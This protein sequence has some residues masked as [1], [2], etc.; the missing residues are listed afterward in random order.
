MVVDPHYSTSH[1]QHTHSTEMTSTSSSY[2]GMSAA[3]VGADLQA[4]KESHFSKSTQ[5]NNYAPK[6]A[7]VKLSIFEHLDPLHSAL[8]LPQTRHR[9]SCYQTASYIPSKSAPRSILWCTPS[10][11]LQSLLPL[12][13]CCR[14]SDRVQHN[15]QRK[16]CKSTCISTLIT[17]FLFRVVMR[18]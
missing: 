14:C 4:G 17:T 2:G 16:E 9:E 12:P 6:E 8:K 18:S 13:A 5:A 11:R 10:R 3:V 7:N 15:N 1:P